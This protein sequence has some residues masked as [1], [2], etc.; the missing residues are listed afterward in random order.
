MTRTR[1]YEAHI[2]LHTIKILIYS[3][4]IIFRNGHQPQ[5]NVRQVGRYTS[6]L[7]V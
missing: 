3:N 6:P 1:F 4:F 5:R 7:R 2:I